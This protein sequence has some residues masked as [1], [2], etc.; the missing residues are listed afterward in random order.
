M[1]ANDKKRREALKRAAVLVAEIRR[2]MEGVT[3]EEVLRA[4]GEDD[5][6]YP[7][8]WTPPPTRNGRRG[9]ASTRT[10]SRRD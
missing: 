2:K 10:A 4:L 6:R 7:E 5:I 3:E 9:S 8:P 1:D